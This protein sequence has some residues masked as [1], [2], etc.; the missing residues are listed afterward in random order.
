MGVVALFLVQRGEML[1]REAQE[2]EE[3]RQPTRVE[4]YVE[5]T[6]QMYSNQEFKA[7]FRMARETFEVRVSAS[8]LRVGFT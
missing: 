5:H 6:V 8:Q 2:E 7:H 4:G 3:R 1:Q